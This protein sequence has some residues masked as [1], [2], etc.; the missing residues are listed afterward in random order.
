MRKS[1]VNKPSK[2]HAKYSVGDFFEYGNRGLFYIEDSWFSR[3]K[4][5]FC[6]TV[7]YPKRMPQDCYR[8]Y[9]ES[10]I[11]KDCKPLKKGKFFPHLFK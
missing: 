9:H 8:A 6:Y 1:L 10:R 11:N 2:V 5:E 3:N 4:N 7:K